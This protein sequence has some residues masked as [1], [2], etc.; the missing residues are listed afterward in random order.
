MKVLNQE[1]RAVLLKTQNVLRRID[2][3]EKFFFNLVVY[4]E[5]LGFVKVKNHYCEY[6]GEKR[7][8]DIT[9][10]LT[11]KGKKLLAVRI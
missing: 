8:K 2:N 5:T 7:I 9:F 4:T 11:E 6:L 1:Q 10:H 3:G